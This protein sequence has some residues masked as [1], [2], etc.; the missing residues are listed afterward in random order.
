MPTGAGPK[1]PADVVAGVT[2]AGTG[3]SCHCGKGASCSWQ[4]CRAVVEQGQDN[5]CQSYQGRKKAED[6]QWDGCTPESL[7]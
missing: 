2:V 5:L 1:G 7:R 6:P 4:R 3:A